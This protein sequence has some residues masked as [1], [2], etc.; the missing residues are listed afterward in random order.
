ML[1]PL[2]L[3]PA[4]IKMPRSYRLRYRTFLLYVLAKAKHIGGLLIVHWVF[5]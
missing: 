5:R 3:H 1:Y 2:N 4:D